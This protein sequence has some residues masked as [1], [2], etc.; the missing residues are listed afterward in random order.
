MRKLSFALTGLAFL[1]FISATTQVSA[2]TPQATSQEKPPISKKELL[3]V[4]QTGGIPP[5]R[6]IELVKKRGVDFQ[7]KLTDEAELGKAGAS[8]E[9]LEAVSANY[10]QYK[11]KSGLV[12]FN[13]TLNKINAA[14]DKNKTSGAAAP[15][16]ALDASAPPPTTAA[17]APDTTSTSSGTAATGGANVQKLGESIKQISDVIRQMKKK[18]QPKTDSNTTAAQPAATPAPTTPPAGAAPPTDAPPPGVL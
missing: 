14:L 15:Q 11:K 12:K 10:R 18:K 7:S 6:L 2:Q 3:A 13:E 5:E 1:L 8:T 16:T 17:P 9:L 4:L